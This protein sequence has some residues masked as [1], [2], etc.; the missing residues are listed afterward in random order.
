MMR[1]YHLRVDL[2]CLLQSF[3][4]YAKGNKHPRNSRVRIANSQPPVVPI[5]GK[6]RRGQSLDRGH[7][8]AY[9]HWPCSIETAA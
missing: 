3:R 6:F 8:I 4:R 9:L 5:V 1:H 2:A 7:N